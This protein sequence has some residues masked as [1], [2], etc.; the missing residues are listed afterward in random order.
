MLKKKPAKKAEKHDFTALDAAVSELS[1]QTAALLGTADEKP[2]KPKL[3]KKSTVPH[4]K[5]KSFDIIHN[6]KQKAPLKASLKTV[7]VSRHTAAPLAHIQ[8]DIAPKSLVENNNKPEA[9]EPDHSPDFR[10]DQPMIRG[11]EKGLTVQNAE[12]PADTDRIVQEVSQDDSV[13]AASRGAIV[14][15]E[16]STK[17]REEQNPKEPVSETVESAPEEPKPSKPVVAESSESS[18]STKDQLD[19]KPVE[20]PAYNS[21]ELFANN[22]VK[23]SKSRGYK[24]HENQQLPTVFDTNEY[25]PK[26]HDWSK[27][28]HDTSL[29][30]FVLILVLVIAGAVAYF[31]ISGQA[32]PFIDF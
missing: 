16:D 23:E 22:L 6:P 21:G 29:G 4:T 20:L 24:P 13:A 1:K 10:A 28:E 14:F 19:E 31:V 9:D 32:I 12:T 18:E 15:E 8:T 25:H 7:A 26:L 3:P 27:L 17:E 5:G 11:H 30:W 2:A